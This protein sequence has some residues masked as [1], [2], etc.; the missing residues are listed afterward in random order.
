M[1]VRPFPH[2]ST[3]LDAEFEISC[4]ATRPT[5]PGP[6]YYERIAEE[7]EEVARSLRDR[8]EMNHHAAERLRAIAR[9]IRRDAKLPPR[10]PAKK[11]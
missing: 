9:D 8:P 6:G 5:P 7:L 2:R 10:K 3:R 11:K 4:M 1:I